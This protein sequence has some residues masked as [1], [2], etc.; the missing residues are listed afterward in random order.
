VL[1]VHEEGYAKGDLA[2]MMAL[3]EDKVRWW[4]RTSARPWEA[5]SWE[6]WAWQ[7][8][9]QQCSVHGRELHYARW[10]GG[11]GPVPNRGGLGPKRLNWARPKTNIQ[12]NFQ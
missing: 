1:V 11:H 10:P 7:A 12:K 5:V 8:V 3:T 4:R 2:S 6:P 9:R